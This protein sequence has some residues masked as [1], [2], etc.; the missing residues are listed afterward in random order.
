MKRIA[1]PHFR[2]QDHSGLAQFYCGL[3]G[4]QAVAATTESVAFGFDAHRACVRFHRTADKPYEPR[5]NDFYWKIGITLRD[6]DAAVA[7][8]RNKGLAVSDPNQFRDIGYMSKIADPTGFTIELLQQGFEGNSKPVPPGGHAIAAQATLAH[9]TLRVTDIAS[10]RTYFEDRLAMRL[11]SVQPVEEYGFCLYFYSWS[12]EP[13]PEPDLTSVGN[14]EWLWS[15]PYA[16]IELQH[17]ETPGAVVRK[18][19]GNTS[20]FDG[21]S[22]LGS[23]DEDPV[24]VALSDLNLLS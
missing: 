1:G 2:V 7:D 16:F 5:P 15:R 23:S 8:L 19:E 13:L 21:F 9:I 20:G 4:M 24:F 18:A 22:Y 17:L 11:M 14:R 10:A 12:D 3:L 6:L